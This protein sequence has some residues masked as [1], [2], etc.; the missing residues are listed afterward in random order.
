MHCQRRTCKK[1]FI[2]S[3]CYV[4]PVGHAYRRDIETGRFQ[5][6]GYY[7]VSLCRASSHS[8]WHLLEHSDPCSQTG[9]EPCPLCLGETCSV[10]LVKTSAQ[11][12]QPRICCKVWAPTS[13]AE[14]IEVAVAMQAKRMAESTTAQPTTNRPIV[15]PKCHPELAARDDKKRK[16]TKRPAIMTYNLRGHWLAKHAG[17]PIPAELAA[18]IALAAHEKAMLNVNKGRALSH[19][20]AARFRAPAEVKQSPRA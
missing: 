20:Q 7:A 8:A 13:S 2:E 10:F 15:C 11:M 5:E 12:L 18:Q 9:L 19:A 1:I 14:N 16:V 3:W 17:A 6:A 4:F